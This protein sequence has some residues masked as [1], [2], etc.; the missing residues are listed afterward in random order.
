MYIV[1]RMLDTNCL[2]YP[3]SS[4][5]TKTVKNMFDTF[6]KIYTDGIVRKLSTADQA[7]VGSFIFLPP[8]TNLR[9]KYEN[10]NLE[11]EIF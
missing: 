7:K 8:F 3:A 11:V 5:L 1:M 2:K 6:Q 4:P 9:L 10:G